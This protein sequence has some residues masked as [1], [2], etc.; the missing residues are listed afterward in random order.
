MAAMEALRR[1]NLEQIAHLSFT[2]CRVCT[3]C[4]ELASLL[5]EVDAAAAELSDWLA[6]TYFTHV[7]DIGRQTMA[8]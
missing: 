6:M 3:P 1:Y 5:E 8:L 4:E 7:G 2:T